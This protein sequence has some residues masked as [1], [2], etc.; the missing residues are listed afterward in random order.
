[1]N[2]DEY[3]QWMK[4][5]VDNSVKEHEKIQQ[6]LVW[7]HEK[8]AS[9][10]SYYQE[11]AL[12]AF[13][14][15]VVAG[16]KTISISREISRTL[17]SSLDKDIN[18]VRGIS[19]KLRESEYNGVSFNPRKLHKWELNGLIYQAR[20]L[21]AVDIVIDR[22]LAIECQRDDPKGRFYLRQVT[23]LLIRDCD[24]KLLER[25]IYWD[26]IFPDENEMVDCLYERQ[27]KEWKEGLSRIL[28][29]YR[30]L[31]LD[32]QF[33]SG[34]K[35]LLERYYATNKLLLDCLGKSN[36]SPEVKK[37]IQE[38]L[39]LPIVEIEKRKSGITKKSLLVCLQESN[40]SI[41]VHDTQETLLLPTVEIE[42]PSSNDVQQQVQKTLSLPTDETAQLKRDDDQSS[43]K[44]SVKTDL[45]TITLFYS[46]LLI[47]LIL[48]IVFITVFRHYISQ[49]PNPVLSQ[50]VIA[51]SRT[52]QE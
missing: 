29:Q 21:P 11:S 17:D 7:L 14:C 18:E 41:E 46:S 6:F 13:Y 44:L 20:T 3:L 36:A 48:Y 24:K 51:D 38:T 23:A 39:L 30:N 5:A 16:A 34:Q 22:N 19:N 27:L 10:G 50:S 8:T 28:F 15:T 37:E 25:I 40:A 9:L 52:S 1:M 35:Q 42:K 12:R 49:I 47:A 45:Y 2:K 31:K 32:W 43:P 33:S 26:E 4:Q